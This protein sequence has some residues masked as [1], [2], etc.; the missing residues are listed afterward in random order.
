MATHYSTLASRAAA[1]ALLLTL[2][3]CADMAASVAPG[4]PLAQVEASYGKPNF[5]CPL[6][7]GGE[8]A[9]WTQQPLGQYAWG[10]NVAPDGRVDRV[11]RVLTDEHFN[12]L[13]QGDWTPQQVRCEFGP[14]A[15]IDEVGLPSVRQIV[16][17]YRYRQDDSWNS[18]MYVYM[19]KD[20]DRV[21]HYHPGPDPMYEHPFDNR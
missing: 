11:T 9:I 17:S 1:A 16:W 20:G 5:T 10:A 19:G 3:A 18:L 7:D 21:T 4:A 6:P 14:P 2:A 15:K 13:A 12:V 8:R